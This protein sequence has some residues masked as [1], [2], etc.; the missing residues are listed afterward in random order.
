MMLAETLTLVLVSSSRKMPLRFASHTSAAQGGAVL[1][2]LVT[3]GRLE[4]TSRRASHPVVTIADASRTGIGVLDR[5]LEIITGFP[6][7]YDVRYAAASIGREQ[8]GTLRRGLVAAG[9]LRLEKA[10]AWRIIPTEKVVLADPAQL[11]ATLTRLREI[12]V[13]GRAAAPLDASLVGLLDELGVLADVLPST[14]L[15]ARALRRRAREVAPADL[16]HAAVR[17]AIRRPVDPPGESV[18]GPV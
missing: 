16:A 10:R 5:A 11:E 12:L 13:E 3:L 4:V 1:L 9:I 7:G 15:G 6:T 2:E 14:A 18:F 8:G 17:A